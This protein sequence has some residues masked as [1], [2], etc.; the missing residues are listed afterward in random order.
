[1]SYTIDVYRKELEPAKHYL[2]YLL[3]LSF[4]PQLVAGPIVRARDFLPQLLNPPTMTSIMGGK[5]LYLISLGLFKKVVIADYL[6]IN[7]V[8]RVFSTP[9]AY[10]SL[11]ALIGVYGYA[12]QIYC[13]FSGYSDIA[14]GCALLLGFEFPENFRTPYQSTD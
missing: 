11:E 7:L 1:M 14:I 2:Q 9:M 4:F 8:D 5:G 13:D 3:Y 6:A 12:F 10:S